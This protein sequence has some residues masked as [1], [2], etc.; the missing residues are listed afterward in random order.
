MT[1]L[2]QVQPQEVQLHSETETLTVLPLDDEK[3]K[4]GN[5]RSQLE[6]SVSGIQFR[7]SGLGGGLSTASSVTYDIIT[8]GKKKQLSLFDFSFCLLLR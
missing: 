4:G 3:H 6:T 5:I 1:S 2:P 8:G 7:Q